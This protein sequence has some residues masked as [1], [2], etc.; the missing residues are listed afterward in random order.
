MTNDP[1]FDIS[2]YPALRGYIERVG[3]ECQNFRRFVV[4]EYHGH[5]YTQRTL[6]K[7][8]GDGSIECKSKEHEP[9]AEEAEAIKRELKDERWP[10]AILARDTDALRALLGT[11][12]TLHE[13]ITR[14]PG[15]SG[16]IMVQQRVM[17]DDGR[18]AYVPWTFFS[19]GVWRKMEPDGALPFWKPSGSACRRARIM[20]H[21]GAKA[22]AFVDALVNSPEIFAGQPAHPWL[23]ELKAYEHWGMIGGALAP[24]RAD[25]E[26]L[27]RERPLE[28][29][30]VCDNDNPGRAALQKVSEAYGRA[31]KGVMF[32]GGWPMSWDMADAMPEW[33]FKKGRY[34]G[35]RLGS[36]MQPATRATK[37]SAVEVEGTTGKKK[38]VVSTRLLEAF[39][40]EWFHS[41]VPE[42]FI[43][44]DWPSRIY[45]AQE[46]NSVVAPFS[47]VDDTAR[48]LKKDA[49]AKSAVL[50]YDP[51]KAPGIYGGVSGRFINT[52]VPGP[53]VSESGDV[54]LWSA[55]LEH[56]VPDNGDRHELMRWCAT[57]IA[58]PDIKM[59]YGVLL[60]SEEQGVGKGTLGEKILAPILGWE[61]V[62]S[63]NEREIV[64]SSFNYWLAHKRL[65]VI[66]EIYQGKSSKG[67]DALKS[68]ITDK[69]ITVSRKFQANYEVENW[70]HVIACSN[71][72][73]ALQ[74]S[75]D[76]RRWFVPGVR[77]RKMTEEMAVRLNEWL[78]EENGLGKI[79]WWA[80][81]FLKSNKAVGRADRAP[82][83][84]AKKV[85]IREGLSPGSALVAQFLERISEDMQDE[86][87]LERHT[88]ARKA[89]GGWRPEGVVITD[90]SLVQMIRDMLHEGRPTDR[91][92]KPMTVRKVA[93]QLGWYISD[94]QARVKEWGTRGVRCQLVCSNRTL[95]EARPEDLAERI[96][97]LEINLLQEEKLS[98]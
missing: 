70:I 29:V 77:E 60:I 62:S 91:L 58:R 3:A 16:I 87:W 76:D 67:Y 6:I 94:H 15:E 95:A 1:A 88:K 82:G 92:E 34:I 63:P 14:K 26:E 96:R 25:Y 65:A 30:Y 35:P 40:E 22:A 7:I 21:E 59:L 72:K 41:V 55:F 90:V 33:F 8:L 83:S 10:K 75:G 64:D 32:D 4:C 86:K 28:V 17:F 74:I 81:E 47:D 24:E 54:G 39:K 9:T 93:R 44:K 43:H 51:A 45:S 52:H 66:H 68:V 78:T 12:A 11:G 42:A 97:P 48:L 98:I 69:M 5:Y 19:D 37:R 80:S 2:A 53:V 18:K 57:L 79:K 46:F 89:N 20:V 49:A 31:L 38:I 85:V 73:R 36:L 50:K 13:F 23:E 84:E 71:S 61:N 56:L 27:Y